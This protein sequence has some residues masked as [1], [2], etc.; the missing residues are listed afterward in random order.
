M[1]ARCSLASNRSP[2]RAAASR[3]AVGVTILLLKQL[4]QF[5]IVEHRVGQEPLPPGVL[6]LQRL[7][8]LRLGHIAAAAFWPS[9]WRRSPRSTPFLRR[10]SA[11]GT[12]AF[13]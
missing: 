7:R 11:V 9:R 6:A 4:L 5:G 2:R 3:G 1:H 12:P 10:T 8:P 13:C